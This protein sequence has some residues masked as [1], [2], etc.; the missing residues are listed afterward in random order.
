MEARGE[1]LQ[2]LAGQLANGGAIGDAKSERAKV[3]N[4]VDT[5]GRAVGAVA[6]PQARVGIEPQAGSVVVVEGAAADERVGT[7]GTEFDA[8]VEHLVE[9]GMGGLDAG[10]EAN[11]K[12]ERR[13][14][15]QRGQ[16]ISGAQK[17]EKGA[18]AGSG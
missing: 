10:D 12:R 7:G 15:S 13:L 1:G 14:W 4:I 18:R 3:A 17:R 9:S 8:G 2:E 11:A 5:V 6:A 16:R